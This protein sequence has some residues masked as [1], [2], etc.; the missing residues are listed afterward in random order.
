LTTFDRLKD[1]R[2][3]ISIDDTT[4]DVHTYSRIPNDNELLG[5]GLTGLYADIP[6]SAETDTFYYAT[7]TMI[8]WRWSGSAWVESTR[9]E[10][11]TRLAQLSERAHSN[12]SGIGGN[13]HHDTD[14]KTRH[15]TVGPGADALDT[16]SSGGHTHGL[17][18]SAHKHGYSV[19]N[20]PVVSAGATLY[21][22]PSSGAS[23]TTAFS[24][25]TFGSNT[26]FVIS[27]DGYTWE[28]TQS[29]STQSDGAH[30][31]NVTSSPTEDVE[32]DEANPMIEILSD[33]TRLDGQRI[34]EIYFK[35]FDFKDK[36]SFP[37]NRTDGQILKNIKQHWHD[38]WEHSKKGNALK[39]T[40]SLSGKKLRWDKDYEKQRMDEQ[41]LDDG[42]SGWR[43]NMVKSIED[44]TA[45]PDD[46][47]RYSKHVEV[48]SKKMKALGLKD[49][50]PKD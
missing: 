29:I 17:N 8:W 18:T 23:P 15:G 26:D 16:G 40:G 38:M 37:S 42:L 35:D 21:A 48:R 10:V 30:T 32:V 22:A 13:D 24:V 7:D 49:K 19:Y 9:A 36:V 6:A 46:E 25:P 27:T 5:L 39:V 11:K 41:L 31:H 45:H 47:L 20:M 2:D 50:K 14:H 12:T 44:G 1:F 34:I 4:D 43:D 3:R 28:A 33:E